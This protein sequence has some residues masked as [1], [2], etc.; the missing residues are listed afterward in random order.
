MASM[1][2]AGLRFFCQTS[3]GLFS[4]IKNAALFTKAKIAVSPILSVKLSFY[5][6]RELSI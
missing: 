2:A 5:M 1:M 4:K 3:L 6:F